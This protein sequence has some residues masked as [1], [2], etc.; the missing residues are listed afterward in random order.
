M[1][2]ETDVIERVIN[3]DTE[4]FRALVERYQGPVIRLIANMTGDGQDCE[5]LAQDVFLAAYAKLKTFDAARSRFSTWLFTI[6]RNTSINAVK[7]QRL[8]A[9][10]R[11][12]QRA[13]TADPSD[14]LARREALAE[15]D[16]AL[17]AL[18]GRQRRALVLVEFEGLSYQEAAQ[19]EGTRIGTIRS[20]I[21]RARQALM[22]AL[23]HLGADEPC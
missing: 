10:A 9:R 11:P 16:E 15:L 3:G 20:R 12:P 23:G 1:T 22:N 7:R 19:V 4:S 17:A 18:P 14:A 8:A 6:A 21:S 2:E 5:G 13:E